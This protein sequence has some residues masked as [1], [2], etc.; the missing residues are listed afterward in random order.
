MEREK[1]EVL[2]HEKPSVS[3]QFAKK[4]AWFASMVDQR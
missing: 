1:G 3:S 2:R 4:I